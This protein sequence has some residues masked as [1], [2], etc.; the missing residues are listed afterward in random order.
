MSWH[1]K[2]KHKIYN[3]LHSRP[4]AA[5]QCRPS[6]NSKESWWS[7]WSMSHLKALDCRNSKVKLLYK[8]RK[9]YFFGTRCCS[10]KFCLPPLGKKVVEVEG[11]ELHILIK[12]AKNL[13]AMKGGGGTS[14]S[15]VKGWDWNKTPR[16]SYD[17]DC[18]SRPFLS[19]FY[20]YLFPS[21]SK[22]TKRKTPVVKKNLNPHYGH[23]FVYKELMLQQLGTMCLELTVWDREPMLSNEFLGGVRLSSGEGKTLTTNPTA[24]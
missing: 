12:E 13:M 20:S 2:N 3:V 8:M 14:D 6:L 24:L 16:R 7:P 19:C 22:T 5:Y 17:I 4:R 9:D 10:L 21:K 23:T 1:K 11:G 18:F 15:F